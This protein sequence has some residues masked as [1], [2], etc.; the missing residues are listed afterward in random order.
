MIRL[1]AT[2]LDIAGRFQFRIEVDGAVHATTGE[3]I[4]AAKI[5][6]NLGVERPLQL[7]E[8]AREWGTIEMLDHPNKAR[9]GGG[10]DPG[11]APS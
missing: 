2:R 6:F 1:V 4:K 7:V 8:H 5:L 11:D 9:D 10:P 3:A